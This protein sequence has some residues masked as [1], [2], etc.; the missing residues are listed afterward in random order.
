MVFGM[1]FNA[2]KVLFVDLRLGGDSEGGCMTFIDI[3]RG[4]MWLK[5][6][7]EIVFDVVEGG[8]KFKVVYSWF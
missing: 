7:L 8:L 1:S 2:A 5:V 4:L 3:Y 6:V